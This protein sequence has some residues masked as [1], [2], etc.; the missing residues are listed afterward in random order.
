M[1]ERPV[2]LITG[3]SRGI[4]AATARMAAQRGYDVAITYRQDEA[5][6]RGV[7]SACQQAG[8]RTEV[9]QAD[10]AVPADIARLYREFDARFERLTHLVNNAGTVGDFGRLD[11][12]DPDML[13]YCIDLNVTGAILMAREAVRRIST[14]NGGPGGV[15]VNLSSGAPE[16]GCAGE[17]VWYAATK[18]AINALTLG[19]GREVAREGLRVVAVAPGL[20]DTEIH[21]SGG[22]PGRVQRNASIVP[23]GRASQPEE[24]AEVILFLM[25]DAASYV[26]GAVWRVSGGR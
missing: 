26:T 13:R 17:Y 6:A 10:V 9:F 22:Q 19:L 2:V 18:G 1:T 24:V 3:G 23:M 21:A 12:A 7:Q 4:G 20:T 25:S 14:R 5:A 15:I 8:A 16:N 11:N